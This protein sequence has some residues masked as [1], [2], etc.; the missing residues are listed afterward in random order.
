M[1]GQDAGAVAELSG[2]LGYPA[3][4]DRM[5]ARF[6]EL[7]HDADAV[8]LVAETPDGAVAGWI[9]IC[10]RR[11]LESDPCAE[12]AG[13]IVDA[14]RRRQGIGRRLV[15]AAEAWS[16]KRGYTHLRVR[17]NVARDAAHVFYPGLG[18]TKVKTQHV[19]ERAV[20]AGGPARSARD[21]G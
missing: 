18:F 17:S 2:Q 13:L 4:A 3:A 10:G 11:T 16:R 12:I 7:A 20:A 6:R 9:H 14:T 1:T 19:Y 15:E 21:K 5:A 8:I